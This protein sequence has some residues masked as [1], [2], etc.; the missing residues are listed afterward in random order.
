M[1]VWRLSAMM[2]TAVCMQPVTAK[3]GRTY[4]TAER[5][6]TARR[7]VSE[8]DWAKEELRRVLES[9]PLNAHTGNWG[10]DLVGAKRVV[11]KSDDEVFAMMP[12]VTVPRRVESK[13]TTLCPVH[14]EQIR[15]YSGYAPWRLDFDNQPWKVVCPVGGETY[16]SNDY[17]AGDMTNG[18]YADDGDGAVV[19]GKRYEFLR[20]YAHKAYL[21]HVIPSLRSLSAAYLVTGEAR[22]AEKCAVLFAAVASNFPG[23]QFHSE[24]CHHH[25]YK[26]RSGMVTDYIWEC[27]TMPLIALAYDAIWPIYDESPQLLAYLQGKGLPADTAAA[28]REFVEQRILRQAMQALLDQAIQGNPG[29]HQL[30][31]ITLALVLDDFGS[32]RTPSSLDMVQFTYYAG[33]APAGWV[34]GNYL[35]PDG[36]GYEGPAYDRIKFSYVDVALR[37]EE[38][39]ERHPELLPDSRFPRL[40]EEPKLRALYDFYLDLT[41]LDAFTPEVGDAG[42]A[43]IRTPFVPPRFISAYPHFYDRGFRI[44]RDP[45]YATALLGLKDEMPSGGD[46]FEPSLEAEARAAAARP[47]GRVRFDTRLLDHYGFAYLRGGD[48]TRPYEAMINYSAFKG[49]YQ[50]DFLTLYLYAHEM[51]LLPDLGYPFTWDYRQTWD[52]NSYTHNTVIVDGCPPL[53][54]PI[55]PRGWV[56]LI[57]DTGD[58]QAAV[59]AHDCYNPKYNHSPFR[60]KESRYAEKHPPVD[61]YERIVVTV[62][63]NEHDAYLLDLFVVEGGKQHDQSWHSALR[64]PTLPDLPWQNQADGTAAGPDVAFNTSYV[65][66]RGREVT[67]GLCFV[68]GVKRAAVPEPATFDWDLKLKHPA[69]MRLHVVPVD[70]PVQL[71][72]GK[73]RSPA[74][75]KEWGLPLLIVRREGEEGL[76]SRFLTLLE[77]YRDNTE[78]RITEV[79]VRGDDWPLQVTVQRGDSADVITLHAPSAEGVLDRGQPREVGI[80]VKTPRGGAQFGSLPGRGP[81]AVRGTITAVDRAANA[82]TIDQPATALA[83]TQPWVRI[84]SPGRSSMVCVTG[85]EPAGDGRARLTLKTTSLLSR[86]LPTAYETGRINNAAPLP[87]AT[88][89]VDEQ[90][91]YANGTCRLA[92]ARVENADGTASLRLAGVSGVHWITG[93]AGYDLYLEE[94]LPAA[95]L[96]AKF[97]P[98]GE[99]AAR[100]PIHDY[101]VGDGVEVLRCSPGAG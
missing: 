78:P 77:P 62:R 17:A 1:R 96:E 51:S 52:G 36:G 46:L 65:N 26:H 63:E 95:E 71:V 83:D 98:P 82:I 18:E 64:D 61:R 54:P 91:R 33:Y 10:K 38:L 9:G 84:H 45:R 70:G 34:F 14:G 76:R 48:E 50:D 67:D 97:G 2:A 58:V 92:G 44:F 29:H 99:N 24:L 93:I 40:L 75:P 30:A 15:R 3:D 22:Y 55:V 79:Q 23:P 13:G 88:G 69:G 74:R 80:E 4:Y 86:A 53:T 56:S 87:F 49:H 85:I 7:N 41:L 81:G 59:I 37:M 21:L 8:H 57:G 12:P 89:S 27:I 11:A 100:L 72:Y 6:E 16:P 94:L 32:Q 47:E 35:T 73:G 25:A 101:G 68:T 5:I 28:A 42:G 20:Y 90:G 43:R 60:V 31:A 19:D 39:R 66:V